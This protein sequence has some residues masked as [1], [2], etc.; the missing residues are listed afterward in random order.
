MEHKGDQM[1]I[2][3]KR[4]PEAL[5]KNWKDRKVQLQRFFT[6]LIGPAHHFKWEET[7]AEPGVKNIWVLLQLY[8]VWNN[9]GQHNTNTKA[10]LRCWSPKS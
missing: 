8:L 2:D 9:Q 10:P 3:K 5:T 7:R 1:N 4:I 6:N